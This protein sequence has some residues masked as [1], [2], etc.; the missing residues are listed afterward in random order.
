MSISILCAPAWSQSHRTIRGQAIAPAP[1]SPNATGSTPDPCFIALGSTP[2]RR[3]QR[4]REFVEHGIHE[5]EL[6][7]IRG[8]VNRNQLTGSEAFIL[9]IE[10]RIGEWIPH[11]ARGRPRS[12]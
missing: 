8:A 2:A 3:Q 12:I 10:Q 9:E 1:A 4:Y 11:R 6:K 7:F 5:H